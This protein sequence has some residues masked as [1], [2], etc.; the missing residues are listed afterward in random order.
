MPL[1][2]PRVVHFA[3]PHLFRRITFGALGM[4][5]GVS[6]PAFPLLAE[7]LF[8]APRLCVAG[9]TL[10]NKVDKYNDHARYCMD[11][12]AR[13]RHALDKRS[14]LL[15]AEIWMDMIPERERTA[16]YRFEAVVRNQGAHL[17]A[18]DL[19]VVQ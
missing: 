13:A 2:V 9:E 6:Q 11:M 3:R 16:A 15:L 19:Q 5:I 8:Y 1:L 4:C 17:R 14:W 18:V 7:A 12:A 10:M